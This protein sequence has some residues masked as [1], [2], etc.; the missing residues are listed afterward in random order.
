MKINGY[1]AESQFCLAVKNCPKIK[2]WQLP[3]TDALLQVAQSSEVGRKRL[4]AARHHLEREYGIPV[5]NPRTGTVSI[6]FSFSAV[7]PQVFLDLV[8]GIDRV[9]IV[10]GY[11][12]AV[13]VT[14]NSLAI[15]EKIEKL[16][17]LKPLWSA[18]GIERVGV[19]PV[20]GNWN[21]WNRLKTIIKSRQE[22]AIV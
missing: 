18:I 15:D 14:A 21:L 5:R 11:V 9:L 16:K 3:T 2:I 10:L 20:D 22:V 1:A 19:F 7:P 8:Y 13:D 12:I 6:S 4:S 17:N